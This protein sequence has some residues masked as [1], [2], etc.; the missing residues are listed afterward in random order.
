VANYI[1]NH[2]LLLTFRNVITT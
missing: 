1:S 2:E